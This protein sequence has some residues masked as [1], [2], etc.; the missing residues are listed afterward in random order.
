MQ[1]T[2]VLGLRR[3]VEDEL[4]GRSEGE[5][6]GAE[7][8]ADTAGRPER[9]MFLA[10]RP[11]NV[12]SYAA[13]QHSGLCRSVGPYPCGALLERRQVSGRCLSPLL[14]RGG[15]LKGVSHLQVERHSRT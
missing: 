15:R 6:L 4:Q 8:R 9:F 11:L 3:V 1:T 5:D 14:V 7:A 10:V 13:I 2:W 12:G